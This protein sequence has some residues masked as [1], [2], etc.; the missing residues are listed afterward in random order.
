MQS[1]EQTPPNLHG[2]GSAYGV[3]QRVPKS[4]VRL[5]F[6]A[7]L[8]SILAGCELMWI[9]GET[10]SNPSR[11]QV[12]DQANARNPALEGPRQSANT[13][14]AEKRGTRFTE[15]GE[16]AVEPAN[17]KRVAKPFSEADIYS[18]ALRRSHSLGESCRREQ[19]P[20]D[21]EAIAL[22][23]YLASR[24]EPD[25]EGAIDSL[26]FCRV[27]IKKRELAAFRELVGEVRKSITFD[28]EEAFDEANPAAQGDLK[29]RVVG[30]EL[31]VSAPGDFEGGRRASQAQI[32]S[33]C[34]FDMALVFTR[35]VLRNSL[36]TFTCIPPRSLSDAE[37]IAMERKGVD[38]AWTLASSAAPSHQSGSTKGASREPLLG[39]LG[40]L[41]PRR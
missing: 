30:T 5:F 10:A 12:A 6:T 31:R 27:L 38:T 40:E 16:D 29:A 14:L 25:R 11:V 3:F 17:A 33:W 21:D 7:A 36:G 41:R 26:E 22:Y 35:V 39:E 20:A 8:L 32:D 24:N 28:V 4:F 18:R 34:D 9:G 23:R 19:P 37:R 1:C 15:G 13:S 2:D